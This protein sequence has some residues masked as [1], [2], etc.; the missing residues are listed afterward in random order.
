MAEK[1]G[2][3]FTV[4]LIQE[5]F[6]IDYLTRNHIIDERCVVVPGY[7]NDMLNGSHLR[8]T[9]KMIDDIEQKIIKGHYNLWGWKKSREANNLNE[10]FASRV[11]QSYAVAY[12]EK[13]TK[14]EAPFRFEQNERFDYYERQ[15]KHIVN[16]VRMYEL[17]GIK[18]VLPFWDCDLIHFWLSIPLEKRENRN[19]FLEFTTFKY[20]D[21]MQIAPVYSSGF[22][23]MKEKLPKNKLIMKLAYSVKFF[24]VAVTGR[25]RDKLNYYG[26]LSGQEYWRSVLKYKT[27]NYYH[28][29][30]RH[31][32]AYLQKNK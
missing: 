19:L 1:C 28:M 31:Y 6:A 24:I 32:L 30:A 12:A 29:F 21:L 7:S 22:T 15:V 5:W 3:S 10:L 8:D 20:P 4:P 18:W 23:Q 11:K 16:A 26:Y 9:H 14:N 17:Y 13:G 27:V 2:N 25:S